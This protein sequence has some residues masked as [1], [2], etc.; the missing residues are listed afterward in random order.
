ML[1]LNVSAS[2]IISSIEYFK[3]SLFLVYGYYILLNAI[4]ASVY[5]FRKESI[6][7]SISVPYRQS[8]SNRNPYG[9]A[10]RQG[11]MKR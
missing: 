8:Y 1:L 9:I 4:Y 11:D 3:L 7:R 2:S 10:L 6:F 5:G